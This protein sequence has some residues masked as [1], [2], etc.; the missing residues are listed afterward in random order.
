ME[1]TVFDKGR[2]PGGRSSTRQESELQ[3][4]HGAQ[5]FT[6]RDDQFRQHAEEWLREGIVAPW[7]A[8]FGV[9]RGDRVILL[10]DQPVRYVG[11]PGMN[12][13]ANYLTASCDVQQGIEV[14]SVV[15]DGNAWRLT[16][17]DGIDLGLYQAV[18]VTTPPSQAASL[19]E[20]AQG[21]SKLAARIQMTPCW[22]VMVA[23]EAALDLQF[24]GAFV[25]KSPLRWIARNGSKPG[26]M[27]EPDCWVLHASPEWSHENL[28]LEAS[29]VILKLVEAFFEATGYRNTT[30]LMCK[31][32][33][34]RYARPTGD[35]K[36]LSLYNNSLRIGAGGDWLVDGRIEGAFLSG[37]SLARRLLEPNFPTGY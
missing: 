37:M 25:E 29:E 9:L 26:R 33:R 5:Y 32:H 11:V 15:R 36:E 10:E 16:S 3:F 17:V 34:W 31:A 28:D 7:D 24:D 21:F 20:G 35:R 19:L 22:A 27:K 14:L 6:V 2:G 30:P 18:L 12:V 13:L 4:D 8:K 23:F 1:V